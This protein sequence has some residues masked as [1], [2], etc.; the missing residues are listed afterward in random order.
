MRIGLFLPLM[1]PFADAGYIRSAGAIAEECGFHSLWVAEHVVLFDD[2]ASPYPYSPDGKLPAGGENH[3]LETFTTLGFLAAVTERIRLGTGICL[4][5]QRNPVYTAKEAANVDFLSGGRLDLG[6]GV[7]WLA[8]EFRAVDTP[9]ERRG[10]RCRSYLEVI[11]QTLARRRL[12]RVQGRVLRASIVSAMNPKPDSAAASTDS[13]RRARAIP[14]WRRVADLG[15]GWYGF[16]L[17]PDEFAER[18]A[19]LRDLLSERGRSPDEIELSVSPYLKGADADKLKRYRDAGADQVIVSAFA[20]DTAR[21]RPT[22]EGLAESLLE[23][24]RSL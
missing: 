19:R 20:P 14:P 10:A 3:V 8:E 21:I 18:V 11:R 13:L 12:S 22:L 15:Q 4:V 17:E 24:A 9:F 7:G 16:N 1:T 6:V 2:Y 23:P 5:P